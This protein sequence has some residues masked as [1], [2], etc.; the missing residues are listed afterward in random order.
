[1]LPKDR[2]RSIPGLTG[3]GSG[4]PIGLGNGSVSKQRGADMI[5]CRIKDFGHIRHNHINTVASKDFK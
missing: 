5:L 1:M 4:S 2:P 3:L